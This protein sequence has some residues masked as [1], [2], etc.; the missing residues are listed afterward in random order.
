MWELIYLWTFVDLAMLPSIN[1]LLFTEHV[2]A[3]YYIDMTQF[4]NTTFDVDDLENGNLC[5]N[6]SFPISIKAELMMFV[7]VI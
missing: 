7:H 6:I 1:K 4:R 3:Y 2:F 5:A